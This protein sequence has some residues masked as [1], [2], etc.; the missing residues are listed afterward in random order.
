MAKRQPREPVW[1]DDWIRQACV[2]RAQQLGYTTEDGKPN[3]YKIA[4]L[5]DGRVH[6]DA[7]RKFLEGENAYGMTSVFL[8]AILEVLGLELIPKERMIIRK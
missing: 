7:V 3:A 2:K 8:C 1:W 4:K 6:Q 5:T